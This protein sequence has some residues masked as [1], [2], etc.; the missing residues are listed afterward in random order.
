[1]KPV[2][3]IEN[4]LEKWPGKKYFGIYRFLP[5]FFFLGAAVEFSMINWRAGKTN[6]CRYFFKYS[7]PQEHFLQ[8]KFTNVDKPKIYWNQNNRRRRNNMPAGVPWPRYLTFLTAATVT[9]F[10]GSQCVHLYYQPL[11]DL[12]KYIEAELKE[13]NVRNNPP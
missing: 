9:M 3:G 7:I 10:A 4:I 11:S 13:R 2:K 6:F 5:I 8:M 12:D 1:M